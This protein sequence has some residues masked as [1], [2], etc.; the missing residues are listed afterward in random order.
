[1]S[2]YRIVKVSAVALERVV[3]CTTKTCNAHGYMDTMQL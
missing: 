3:S 2:T 1:M